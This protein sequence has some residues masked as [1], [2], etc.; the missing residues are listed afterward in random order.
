MQIQRNKMKFQIISWTNFVLRQICKG[1][2][3]TD[4]FDDLRLQG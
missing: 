4:A 1:P 3:E 2:R